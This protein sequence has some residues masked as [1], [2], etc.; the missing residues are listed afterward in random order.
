MWSWK[1]L[2]ENINKKFP[3][4]NESDERQ[5]TLSRSPVGTG[6]LFWM[7]PFEWLFQM[8]GWIFSS[9]SVVVEDEV[10]EPF[11]GVEE[12]KKNLRNGD[13]NKRVVQQRK[14]RT[15]EKQKEKVITAQALERDKVR[16]YINFEI[17]CSRD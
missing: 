11:G 4:F 8:L 7:R 3:E 15:R 13:V 16:N 2:A 12:Y 17:I 6:S 5:S 9:S 14:G 10:Q 1:G